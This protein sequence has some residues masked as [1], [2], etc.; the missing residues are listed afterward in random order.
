MRVRAL[1]VATAVSL[2]AANACSSS[3]STHATK[4]TTTSKPTGGALHAFPSPGTVS[5]S[6]KTGITF[7]GNDPSRVGTVTVTGTESGAH[8]GRL[9]RHADGHGVVFVPDSPFTEGEQVTVHTRADVAGATKGTFRFTV[10][11][12]YAIPAAATTTTPPG[13]T[14]TTADRAA[15]IGVLHFKSTELLPPEITR[16][17][18][19]SPDDVLLS[20]NA[21]FQ[22]GPEIVGADG[23][24]V[25]FQPITKSGIHAVDVDVQRYRGKPVLTWYEGRVFLGFGA[26]EFVVADQHYHEIARVKAG[27]GYAGGDPHEFQ[28]TPQGTALFLIYNPVRG[29]LSSVGGGTDEPV[30]D[31]IVQEVDVKTG[32][33]LFEWHSLGVIPLQESDQ[34]PDPKSDQPFDYLHPNSIALDGTDGLL[35]SARF[36]SAIYRLNRASGAI[37]WRL[38]GTASDFEVPAAAQFA[39][40]HDARPR[41]DGTISLFD[42]GA[43]TSTTKHRSRGL[44]LKVDERAKTVSLVH[45]FP[46]P[47]DDVSSSQGSMR[48]LSTGDFLVGWGNIGGFT[49]FSPDGKVVGDARMTKP[50]SS[51]RALPAARWVGHPTDLPVITVARGAAGE[52]DVSVSW[53]GATE[54]ATWQVLAGADAHHLKP[55]ASHAR[56]GFETTIPV[57]TG[58]T[59]ATGAVVVA[60]RALD[61]SGRTLATSKPTNAS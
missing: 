28:I 2:A 58:A 19:W 38:G 44:I 57:A 34:H 24:P 31:G 42:N 33:V 37:E 11:R 41:A 35:V 61:A 40:Q 21:S 4:T 56:A 18:T 30:V 50:T 36:T 3:S 22:N 6:A 9:H 39:Y 49:E 13:A 14:T 7:R 12:Q 32:D 23:Q 25:W 47:T 10:A 55:V 54:V 46:S 53:N 8:P 52:L 60:V 48:E 26:G 16:T 17:G 1:I 5:A 43:T 59:G 20:V 29:D 27:N 51:F 15:A 45:E